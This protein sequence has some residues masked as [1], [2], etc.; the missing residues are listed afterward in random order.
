M[1]C[2]WGGNADRCG[3][4][5]GAAREGSRLLLLLLLVAA[6]RVKTLRERPAPLLCIVLCGIPPDCK[7]K[8]LY[9][10]YGASVCLLACD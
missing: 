6:K 10:P 9:F 1:H 3:G 4:R 2:R 5:C 8:E 7:K